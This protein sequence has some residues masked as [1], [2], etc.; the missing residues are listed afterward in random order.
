MRSGF[1]F[2]PSHGGAQISDAAAHAT[3]NA[4]TV[5][6]FSFHPGEAQAAVSSSHFHAPEPKLPR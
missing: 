2:S 3:L 1:R 4:S 5:R 6:A